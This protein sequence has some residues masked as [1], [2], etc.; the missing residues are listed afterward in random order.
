[1]IPFDYERAT[2]V[3]SAVATVTGDPRASFLAG[4][5][6]LVDHMK[7]G[8][9]HPHL[10]V[11]VSRLPLDD[12]AE[13]PDG[14]LRIGA[15]VRNS[16][17][18]A[19]DV[20]RARYPMLS[21]ALLSGASGQLRN[22]ATTAGNLLQRT[23]CVYFQDVSTPCNKR[24]P[25]TGCSAIGGYVR[26]HAILGASEHCV[27]VHP[28]DMAVAMAALDGVVVVR[29]ADG[30][31][32][33]PLSEFYRL[34]GDRPEHDTVLAHGDLVTAVELPPPPAGN[35]SAYRKVRDRASFAFALVSVAAELTIEDASITSAR[36]ALGGVA[37]RPW[38]ATL[39]EEVLVESQPT[40]DTFTEAA[41][42]ELA[43]AQPLPGNEF[44]VE[45]TRRVLVSVL[46]SLTEEARR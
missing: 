11:D 30:E 9:A 28:S 41:G 44:K 36:V 24:E 25:G 17:L 19:H 2:D 46:R 23:R 32:R 6:N 5:T 18:A 12:V 38:R 34:P 26:Y 21:R 7:L 10:L 15:A 3:D 33:I 16:D 31:R 13:L 27:A 37:H 42:A 1:M 8:V 22:V 43:A 35:R 29:S 40:E 45:L 4:G 20:V 39:A 14:G